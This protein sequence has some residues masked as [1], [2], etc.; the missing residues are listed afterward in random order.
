MAGARPLPAPEI[1]LGIAVPAAGAGHRGCLDFGWCRVIPGGRIGS[2]RA[3]RIIIGWRAP[4][5]WGLFMDAQ[6]LHPCATYG[7]PQVRAG[8]MIVREERRDISAV[9]SRSLLPV[10]TVGTRAETAER[11][12]ILHLLHQLPF[13]P[14]RKQDPI[15]LTRI[16]RSGRIEGR[17]MLVAERLERGI[18]AGQR[19]VDQLASR[20]EVPRRDARLEL[21]MAEQRSARLVRPAYLHPRRL[22]CSE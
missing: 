12:V 7:D 21:H 2:G 10:K 15:R 14:N 5:L 8:E 22:Q 1:D 18:E 17:P 6:N 4:G 19:L 3:V 20:A 13:G 11:E 9:S 16:S